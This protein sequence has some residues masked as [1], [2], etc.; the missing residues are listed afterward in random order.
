MHSDRFVQSDCD[1]GGGKARKE[2]PS[3]S[4]KSQQIYNQQQGWE[5]H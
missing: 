5:L 3:A 2:K 1:M 4:A